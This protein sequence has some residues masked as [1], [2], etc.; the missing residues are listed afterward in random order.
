MFPLLIVRILTTACH[1][2]DVV[3][4]GVGLP[5][6]EE[7]QSWPDKSRRLSFTAVLAR[8]YNKLVG[9]GDDFS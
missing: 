1:E 2:F 3:F 6:A 5:Q 7:S 8:G 9:C 4:G